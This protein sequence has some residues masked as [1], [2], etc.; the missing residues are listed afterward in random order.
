MKNLFNRNYLWVAVL[1]MA[2]FS[3]QDTLLD[4]NENPNNPTEASID[5]LLPGAQAAAAFW[6]TRDIEEHASIF[7]NHYYRLAPSQH[8]IDGSQIDNDWN[9]LYAAS[10]KE[11]Q[12]IIDDG[13]A[14]GQWGHVGIAKVHKAHLFAYMVDVFGDV[15]FTEA[16]QGETN[17]NPVFDNGESIYPSLIEM[18]DDAKADLDS[19]ITQGL[20][21]VATDLVYGGNFGDWQK[22]ANTLL[23]KLWVTQ[24]LVDPAGATSAINALI[25]EDDLIDSN[26]DNFVFSFASG[27]N[28]NNQHPIY[29]QE[30]KG[31][32]AKTKYMNNYFMYK[33]LSK[34]DPRRNYYVYKQGSLGDLT[35]ELTPCNTRTD[36]EY[37]NL[38]SADPANDGYIGRDMGD[39]SGIPGDNSIR[40]TWGVY[41]VGGS[42]DD[43]RQTEQTLGRGANGAGVAPWVTSAM[44]AFMLAES[45][46]TL[47]TTGDAAGLLEEAIYESMSWVYGWSAASGDPNSPSFNGTFSSAD[48]AYVNARLADYAAASTDNQRLNV[49]IEEK[50]FSQFGNGYESYNDFRRTG[51]PLDMPASLVPLAPYPIRFPIGQTEATSNPNAPEVLVTDAVFWDPN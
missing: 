15:P 47:G 33:L 19:A 23:L 44:R 16:L 27:T 50:F 48:S 17:P 43:G 51:M 49:I 21:A 45:A 8:S 46:L 41:P 38:L 3:C 13:T 18:L 28:P 36:C 5:N 32:G 31:A 30:F 9:G 22:A 6:T 42:Y 7:V 35:F 12:A 24:R 14:A 1:A 11:L 4:I 40:S 26:S 29:Q 39:P 25:A 20:P 34:D 10:L 2:S 37:W